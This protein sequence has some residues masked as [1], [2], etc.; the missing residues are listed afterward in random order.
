V[1][2]EQITLKD[3][4]LSGKLTSNLSAVSKTRRDVEAQIISAK[5]DLECAQ[6]YR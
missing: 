1:Q 6:L 3:M 2:V 4:R 5:A